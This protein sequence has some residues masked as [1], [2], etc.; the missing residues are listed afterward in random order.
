M[1]KKRVKSLVAELLMLGIPALIRLIKKRRAERKA[2]K[3][4]KRARQLKQAAKDNG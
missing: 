2:L 4:R 3:A 1:N